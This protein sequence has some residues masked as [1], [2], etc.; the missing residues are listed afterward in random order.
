ME[1]LLKMA[2]KIDEKVILNVSRVDIN[3]QVIETTAMKLSTLNSYI[4]A[5]YDKIESIT[6]YQREL[7]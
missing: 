2:N 3:E 1:D 7:E 6:I 4:M 5:V